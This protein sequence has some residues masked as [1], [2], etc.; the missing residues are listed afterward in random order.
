MAVR[1]R[2]ILS[3][4]L[5]TAAVVAGS[6]LV[7]FWFGNRVFEVRAREQVRRDGITR[8]EQLESV[9]KDAETGQRGF[10]ITGD[11]NYLLP[12]TRATARLPAD[13]ENLRKCPSLVLAPGEVAKV[14]DLIQRKMAELHST[15]EIRR[16][17][18]FE[19]ALPLVRAGS[20]KQLMDDLRKEVTEVKERQASALKEDAI[21]STRA[22]RTRTQVFL[23][24]GSPQPRDAC[25]GLSADRG[26]FPRA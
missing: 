6:A 17:E 1:L 20:G 5:I 16:S 11:E 21:L 25:L 14:T 13:L 8:L 10:I 24:C 18:G 15:I 12:F 9:V 22:T 4:F 19:A 3:V 2:V 23:L 26:S 7:T